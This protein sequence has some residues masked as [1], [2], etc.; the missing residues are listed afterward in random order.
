M[1]NI[2]L[3]DNKTQHWQ[4]KLYDIHNRCSKFRCL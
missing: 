3:S 2:S 4:Q 1:Q